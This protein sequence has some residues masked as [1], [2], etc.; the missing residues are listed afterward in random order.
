MRRTT[1]RNCTFCEAICG[2]VVETEGERVLSVRGDDDDPMSR[3]YICP[4]AHALKAVYEDPDRLRQ[5]LR[6]TSAGWKEISWDEALAEAGERLVDVRR[7][8]GADAIGFYIGNPTGNDGPA[9]LYAGA[10]LQV[11]GT[12]RRYSAS[13][14]D[15]LPK[16]LANACLYGGNATIAVP[17]VDRTD[18]FLILGANPVVSNGSLMTAPGIKK[19]LKALRARGGRLVVVDPRR[20]ETAGIADE[21]LSIR[22][23]TDAFFLFA[24][25]HTLFEET[26]VRPGRL[27]SFTSGIE[28]LRDL[29]ADFAPEAVA[30]ATGI[31][32]R[33]IRRIAREFSGARSAVCYGRVGA[34]VQEFGTLTNWLCDVLN[35]LTGNLDRAGGAMFAT[36]AVP[37]DYGDTVRELG[38]LPYARWRSAVRGL[39]EFAGELPTSTIAEDAEAGALRALVL[40]AGNP[41]LSAPDGARLAQALDRMDF[42]LSID[43]Y[44]NETSRHAHLILPPTWSLERSN[45]D[46]LFHVWSVRNGAKWS[47][48]ALPKPEGSRHAWE[49]F[50]SL[51]AALTGAPDAPLAAVD[52]SCLRGLVERFVGHAATSTEGVTVDQA[53]LE[54]GDEP[55]PERM[56][57]LLLRIGPY[58]DAFGRNPDGW[59]LPK[60]RRF[61]HGIDLGALAP[62]LPGLLTTPSGRI[63]LAHELFVAD[64]P[65]LR[66]ALGAKRKG[67]QLI[68]RRE[69]RSKNSW[70]HNV[71]ALMKGPERCTLLV[72]PDDA[73]R[74]GLTDGGRARVRTEVGEVVAPV[75]VSDEM[76][77]GVVCLPHGWGHSLEGVDLRIAAKHPGVPSNFVADARRVDVPSG[78]AVLTGIDVEVT[79][80]R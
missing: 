10:L 42:V 7:R 23:A 19:R 71:A 41:V 62:S 14:L 70:L 22:P 65:R 46:L 8:H 30:D 28:R 72:H 44:R 40:H 11:L 45:Y 37:F 78:N 77:L 36:P 50:L 12:K 56:I 63:E 55:G 48:P 79:A 26:L 21:H 4:K 16:M 9:I 61:E 2:V 34:S 76:A 25:V 29:A 32:A 66:E 47:P 43:V 17:D 31:E 20:T 15:Q 49:L 54:L 18:Y 6:R 75:E 59:N 52:A 3:G 58:G 24:I 68:G 64:V 60:L 53:L 74:L 67:I 51:I 13:S 33:T 80:V 73:A 35:V 38:H 27:E 69:L 5:P 39:P 1:Y 57:D